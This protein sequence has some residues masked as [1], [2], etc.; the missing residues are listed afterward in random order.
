MFDTMTG[1]KVVGGVCGTLLIFLFTNWAA[2]ALYF[3][4]EGEGATAEKQ[5]YT[6][7][8]ADAGASSDATTA[9]AAPTYADVYKTADAAKGEALFGKCKACHRTDG[10]NAVGPHLNGVL[11]RKRATVEGFSYSSAMASSH[12]PW[13]P[14]NIFQ[15]IKKPSDYVPG[16]KMGF[17]GLPDPQQRADLI[18]YLATISPGSSAAPTEAA[19]PAASSAAPA[20]AP[21]ASSEAPAAAPAAA[22][23]SDASAGPTF[24]DYSDKID[25]AAGKKVFNKCRACHSIDGKNGVGP[26]LNGVVG[27]DRAS[28]EGFSYSNAM[29]ASHTPWTAQ[30]L[31]DFLKK[32]SDYVKGTKMPFA[33]LADPQQRADLIGYLETQK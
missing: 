6:I 31:F 19:A 25:V 7:Q 26:H 21:A 2:E 10:Q 3:G 1:V 33:G 11:D 23:G 18:A 17:A 4:G 30:E 32:P 5:A 28:V 13:T 14:E 12:D 22:S 24:A 8:V 27:R 9:P 15:F 16:T 20:A 29:D